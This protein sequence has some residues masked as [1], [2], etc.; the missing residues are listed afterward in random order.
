MTRRSNKD[1]RNPFQQYGNK[2]H[3][4]ARSILF[5]DNDQR[6]DS[7]LDALEAFDNG[8]KAPLID[9]MKSGDAI[10]PAIVPHLGDLLERYDFKR[11]AG[12]PRKPSYEM[13][14]IDVE[15]SSADAAVNDL[16]ATG[17]WTLE[18]AV[19][20]IAKRRGISVSKLNEH[21]AGRRRSQRK[22]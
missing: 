13:S 21:H 12:A 7:W 20:A 5:D 8:N 4:P 22:R 14:E 6:T 11:P 19:A 9:L 16:M 1:D 10:P 3:R 17:Q 2:V 18:D 15:L